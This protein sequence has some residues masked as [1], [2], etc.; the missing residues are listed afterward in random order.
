M[1]MFIEAMR[2]KRAIKNNNISHLKGDKIDDP[3]HQNY[4][5]RKGRRIA[6]HAIMHLNGPFA[7]RE[8]RG[9]QTF[10]RIALRSARPYRRISAA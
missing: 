7:N 5:E 9:C 4:H 2:K 6:H 8:D 3:A 1:Y 10:S